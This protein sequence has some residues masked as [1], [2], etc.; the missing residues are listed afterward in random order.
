VHDVQLELRR[1]LHPISLRICWL[2]LAGVAGYALLFP[3]LIR[4]LM[5]APLNRLREAIHLL[6]TGGTAPEVTVDRPDEIGDLTGAFN[7]MSAAIR[8]SAEALRQ[9]R[10]RL[11]DEVAIR[12]AALRDEIEERKRVAEQLA[13]SKVAAEAASQAKSEFLAS[14]SHEIRTPM[15]GIIGTAN[16]LLETNLT[17]DQRELV[18]IGRSSSESLLTI[19]NDILDFSKIEAG[20]MHLEHIRLDL[21]ELLDGVL[22]TFGAATSSRFLGL[23]WWADANVPRFI[24]GDPVRLR[25]V[26]VNL[27][28]NAVKFTREGGVDLYLSLGATPAGETRLRVAVRDTGIGMSEETQGRLFRA[29]SQADS[30]T[31]RRFGGTGLGLVICRQRTGR[32]LN[33]CRNPA[34]HAGRQPRRTLAAGGQFPGAPDRP[35][36]RERVAARTPPAGAGGNAGQSRGRRPGARRRRRALGRVPALGQGRQPRRPRRPTDFA[37]PHG[38]TSNPDSAGFGGLLRRADAAAQAG[39]TAVRPRQPASRPGTDPA[40]IRRERRRAVVGGRGQPGER[41]TRPGDARPP[42][43]R[44]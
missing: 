13:L 36:F 9:H 38:P 2:T 25:Q 26:L 30:S 5:L 24:Q 43:H 11:E 20:Q 22:D 29:F 23:L 34:A 6:E 18:E 21:R 14:M 40:V 1:Q 33:L 31:T 41:E 32:R 27:V 39:P 17:R 10:D 3:L 37:E 35:A 44:P 12:T 15:N 7:R 8:T 4:R 42:R 28:N 19:V 16:L